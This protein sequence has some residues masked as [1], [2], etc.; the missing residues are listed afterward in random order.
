MKPKKAMNGMSFYVIL[1]AVIIMLSFFM[2]RM[3][4]PETTTL[5]DLISEIQS[6]RVSTVTVTSYNIEIITADQ[7][8]QPGQTYSKQVSPCGWNSFILCCRMLKIPA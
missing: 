6:G 7:P 3:T 5:S 1:L 4:Q 8:G 2:S